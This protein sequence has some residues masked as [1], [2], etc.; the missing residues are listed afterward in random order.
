MQAAVDEHGFAVP[1]GK[2]YLTD[3]GYAHTPQTHAP[4][5]NTRYHLQQFGNSEAL[6]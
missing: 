1:E 2:Y 5:R 4:F 3:A 6:R